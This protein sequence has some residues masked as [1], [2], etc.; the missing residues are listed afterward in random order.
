[1]ADGSTSALELSEA[2]HVGEG[3]GLALPSEISLPMTD[4]SINI[5]LSP[6]S[7]LLTEYKGDPAPGTGEEK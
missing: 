6:R 7:Y 1:M 4:E 5:L 3:Q 2:E